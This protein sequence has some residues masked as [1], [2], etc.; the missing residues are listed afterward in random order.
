MGVRFGLLIWIDN[1]PELDAITHFSTR[2]KCEK[3]YKRV[4]GCLKNSRYTILEMDD[5]DDDVKLTN[6]LMK[7]DPVTGEKNPYPSHD[8]QYRKY[9]G[10]VAWLINPYTGT[11]RDARDIGSDVMGYGIS[12]Q[13]TL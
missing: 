13:E 7:F 11:K 1:V 5:G 8:E 4:S 10:V 9:H 2:E 6:A 3:D 12:T